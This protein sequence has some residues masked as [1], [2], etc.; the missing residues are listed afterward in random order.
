MPALLTRARY[1]SRGIAVAAL[2]AGLASNGPVATRTQEAVTLAALSIGMPHGAADAELLRSAARGSRLRHLG[3]LA[4]YAALATAATRVVQRGGPR[5]ERV[6]LLASAAHFAEG[7]LAC[8]RP[9]RRAS[10][11]NTALR[12]ATAAM[13]T[14]VLPSLVSST[15][16]RPPVVGAT[17]VATGQRRSALSLLRDGETPSRNLALA[18]TAAAALSATLVGTGDIE[19]GLDSALLTTVD[20]L[21]PPALAFAAYFGGWHSLRHTA[22]VADALTAR[23]VLPAEPSLPRAAAAIGRRSAW[24]AGI[25]LAAAGV[26]AARDPKHASDNAFAAVLGL[27]VPHMLTVAA[28][29]SGRR[30]PTAV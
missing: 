29:L 24:A 7:E 17:A 26:L 27:T 6:V 12:A 23:G 1:G 10:P 19:A 15:N 28:Q 13:T 25:G 21:A 16:R 11:A 22:R 4:G 30:R 14:A 5:V 18:A 20:L 2:A 9:S 3:L 8:W